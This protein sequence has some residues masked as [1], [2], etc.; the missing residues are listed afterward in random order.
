MSQTDW[1]DL[2]DTWAGG[3]WMLIP[4]DE[5]EKLMTDLEEGLRGSG[6]SSPLPSPTNS[7]GGQAPRL[8]SQDDKP[9]ACNELERA[10]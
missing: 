10:S 8:M 6:Y 1:L 7:H 5:F 4:E 2:F 3:E 9:S